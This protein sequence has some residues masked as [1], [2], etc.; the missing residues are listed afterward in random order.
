MEG[1]KFSDV[2]G[3]LEISANV[4]SLLKNAIVQ[5]MKY[6]KN[7]NEMYI[8]LTSEKVVNESCLSDFRND[9]YTNF[10]FVKDLK[11]DL[12]YNV[13]DIDDKAKVEKYW[14][15]ILNLV[16][17]SSYVCFS[18]FKDC[19]WVMEGNK[20]TFDIGCNCAFIFK[21]KR[22]DVQISELL[23]KRFG[24][25]CKIEF[26]KNIVK[27]DNERYQ[28]RMIKAMEEAEIAVPQ[29][30]EQRKSMVPMNSTPQPQGYKRVK[31][32]SPK[33]SEITG[34]PK[35]LR[36]VNREEDSIVARGRVICSEVIETRKG[37]YIIKADIT[38]NTDSIGVKMF[39]K[40][41][42][43][44][45]ELIGLV[46]TGKYIT[47]KGRVEM[48]RY[49][50]ELVIMA[51]EIA[52]AKA[53]PVR[54]DDAEVKRVELHLH[55]Q[56][57][58]MD[59][60]NSASDYINRALYWGH[61]AIA[62]TDHGVVQ[63]YPEALHTAH[64]KDIK[65]LYGCEIYLVD[66]LGSVVK[67]S[68]GQSLNEEYVVFDLE[69]T[70]LK[71]ES[72]KIIEIGAVK[73]KNGVVIDKYST[74]INPQR[75]LEEKIVKLTGISDDML[76]DAR[77]ENEVMPEFIEFIKGSVL[78]AHNAGFD[79]GFVRQW[80]THNGVELQNTVL[81]TLEL[82]RTLFPELHN[83]KLDTVCKRLE[84]SLENHHRAVDDAG[85]TAEI[86]M[87]C[88]DILKEKNIDKLD[89]LNILAS[90]TIDKRMIKKYYHAIVLVKSQVGM[91][92]L[93]E[94]VS[95]SHIEYYNR[96]PK[97]PK[98]ELIKFREGLII[99]SACEAGDLYTAVYENQP[100]ETI[101]ELVDFYDYL[102][103][104][105]LGNNQFMIN[106]QSKNGKSVDSQDR[107]VELNKKI[108]ELGEKYNKPVVATCDAHFLDPEDEFYRRIIQTGE[109]FKDV[110]NQAP[111]YYRTTDEM[112]EEFE[113]LG[114]DKAYEIVVTNT[115][116]I[117]DSIDDVLPIPKEKCPPS[118]PGAE[119]DLRN[120][121]MSKAHE[122]YGE[123][124]PEVVEKRL[125][126]EL[127]CIIS[128]GY[129]V[130][131]I[132]AQKLVW[133][134][135]DHGYIVG[136]RGSVGSSFAATMLGITEV[137]PLAPHYVCP[138]CKYSDFESEE[139]KANAGNSGFDLPDKEC[140]VC[141]TMLKKDGQDIPFETF[142][143][144]NGDKEPDIDLN[145]SGEYQ[146]AAHRYCESL[147]GEGHVFKAGTIGTVAEKTAY[148]YVLKYLE[149]RPMAMRKA[150][151]NRLKMGCVGIKRTTGQH[152][153][154]LIVVPTDNS[155]YNFCP[156]Q[157]PANDFNSTVTTT[158]FD[159]HSIDQN[160]LKL[161]M[162]G[163]DVPTILRMFLDI[164][165]FDPLDVPMDDKETISL[166]T[167]TKA[168]K[169]T[170]E[171]I[172]C[173][174][175][176]LGLPEFGTAFV[177]Q[178]L[179]ETQPSTFSE[180]V[181]ISG[182]SHGTDVWVG[183]AQ[184]LVRDG[185]A[186]LKEIIPTRD[187]IMVY[188]INKG[189]DNLMA[190]KIMEL[191]RK[192]NFMKPKF[193]ADREKYEATMREHNVPEW[194]I[195]SCKKIKYMF[196]K[197]HAVAYVTNTFRIG[198]FKINYPYAF[199]AATFYVKRDD[200]DYNI[201]CFG[202]EKVRETMQEIKQQGKEATA[203]DKNMLTTLELVLEMYARGL[204]FVK[205]DLY[206]SDA[207][208]FKVTDDGLLPPLCTVQGL[209]AN[210]AQSIVDAREQGEFQTIEELKD[211]AKLGKTVLQ[212]LRDNGVLDGIPETNQLTLF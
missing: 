178:M 171:E 155:I 156:V 119:E 205:M 66:D 113:Y 170:E 94:L 169:V 23:K 75:K 137:N 7:V 120:I 147:F 181:R 28:K 133:D 207:V 46:K 35:A 153:G 48:D 63:A 73:V 179:L 104:Q 150:E 142:L 167:S 22:I 4:R 117:A 55:T 53:P 211:R 176:S 34:E 210:A 121:A 123:P 38:D 80:A 114:K 159:Y 84:V 11:L 130:L 30:I 37:G 165:G 212:L 83:H 149:S 25:D 78:V 39:L 50:Q 148:G 8:A 127:N 164:T 122:V 157:R 61:K 44:T 131:Y 86:F 194:Y 184:D 112:L 189:V 168:L 166:F 163:H 13:G 93:Y 134:S 102:E 151:M 91:R 109:G 193:A 173:N 201:M 154:G 88:I 197:G 14:I 21:A 105:P 49:E 64:G 206:E 71:K 203:K 92:N 41:D 196:P 56:M 101:K 132:I 51:A 98:S 111:L 76:A 26:K 152:P 138:N 15:N 180:L 118:I 57:S 190:F 195:D 200:F 9:I 1:K 58:M 140:P 124:L 175:G 31:R 177:R 161:D 17:S 191:V 202:I 139:V 103:I 188:L 100:E 158:H 129:A 60:I 126:R 69:T 204:K 107:L 209:G 143:G 40:A 2:F 160:L 67:N 52:P 186:T 95:K 106:N 125:E 29:E 19:E 108:V 99:G 20:I 82:A 18:Q 144:F 16:K 90:E 6:N 172:D 24:L 42:E 174:T 10:P 74:F 79:V 146:Q 183:N 116:M 62:I 96:R 32:V 89:E 162:L 72:D 36:F 59:G 85:A 81:D 70:G 47:V 68:Q 5:E 43:Y 182:L 136:S 65:I 192:G 110:D 185:V 27:R 3:N 128:N 45:D 199:Y 198:Y 135:M 97:M 145:F 12:K 54:G 187:D 115:N 87:K 208:K 141:G 33:I 77:T